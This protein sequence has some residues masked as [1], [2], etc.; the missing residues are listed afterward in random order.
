M[1]YRV[2]SGSSKLADKLATMGARAEGAVASLIRNVT[3]LAKEAISNK[4]TTEVR[5]HNR[6]GEIVTNLVDT[7]TYLK[8]WTLKYPDK[9]K[10]ILGTNTEYAS[11]LEYGHDTMAGFFVA[12][13][14]ARKMRGVFRVK[15][16]KTLEDLSK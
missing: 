8:S 2:V 5:P 13:D 11:A 7:G 15:A 12:R 10:G 9:F 6:R 4:I 14:T 1:P 16:R 3:E